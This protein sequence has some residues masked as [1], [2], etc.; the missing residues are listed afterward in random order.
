MP[1]KRCEVIMELEKHYIPKEHERRIYENWQK[2]EAFKVKGT[3]KNGNYSIVMPPP[4]V[5]GVLHMGHA[6]NN[7]LQDILCRWKRMTG[8]EVLWMPGTDHAG[9]HPVT[10]PYNSG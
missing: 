8:H 1:R 9:P 6:L 7:T 4:N 2:T 10:R 3:A 5:T